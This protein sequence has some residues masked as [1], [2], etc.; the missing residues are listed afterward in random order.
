M[1]KSES[2]KELAIALSKAQGEMPAA[3]MTA[4]NPFLRNKYADLGSII[5]ASKPVLA[6][7]GLAVAQPISGDGAL[8]E[9]TTI[10]MHTSGEWL[11]ETVSLPLGE[12]KGKSNAQVAGSIVTYLRR[13]SLASMLGMYADEDT[14]GG[15]SKPSAPA[16]TNGKERPTAPEP[17]AP[18]PTADSLTW[19][20]AAVLKLAKDYGHPAN[21]IAN[22]LGYCNLPKPSN[23]DA[24]SNWMKAYRAARD[25][26]ED[27][28]G[29]AEIANAAQPA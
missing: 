10:L 23:Y 7:H 29:A 9:V 27:V 15:A 16:R 1:E 14:D 6:K 22:V 20:Q 21:R 17:T 8:I 5:Q 26:G 13:Y 4:T 11:S 28:P 2:I 25:A 19:D 24:L 12:E 3:E 18:E